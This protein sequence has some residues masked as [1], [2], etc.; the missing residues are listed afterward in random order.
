MTAAQ[1]PA[2]SYEYLNC[3]PK[4]F[5]TATTADENNQLTV[6]LAPPSPSLSLSLSVLRVSAD[7]MR[8]GD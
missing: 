1:L 4:K 2:Q 6:S 8:T 7:R 5:I 3:A